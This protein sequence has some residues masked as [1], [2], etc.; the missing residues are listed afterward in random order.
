MHHW[1]DATLVKIATPWRA[2]QKYSWKTH[3]K[4]PFSHL[5]NHQEKCK[6]PS[7]SHIFSGSKSK[8]L[9]LCGRCLGTKVENIQDLMVVGSDK[10]RAWTT[11]DDAIWYTPW[12]FNIAPENRPSQKESSL[13]PSFF[14]GYVK[15]REGIP[16]LIGFQPSQVVVEK[17]L[18]STVSLASSETFHEI[19]G[20]IHSFTTLRTLVGES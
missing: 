14:R 3:T 7:N 8:H 5:T 20:K 15:L 2:N 12:K 1:Y 9:N 10:N 13:P 16:L 4:S 17:F 6:I 19:Y 11:K 18:E